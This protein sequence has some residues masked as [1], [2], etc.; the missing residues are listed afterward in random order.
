MHFEFIITCSPQKEKSYKM[1]VL[2]VANINGSRD[3]RGSEHSAD[4]YTSKHFMHM[5]GASITSRRGIS[6]DGFNQDNYFMYADNYSKIFIVADGHGI[7]HNHLRLIILTLKTISGPF[8]GMVSYFATMSLAKS[9]V[10]DSLYLTDTPAALRNAFHSCDKNLS[11]F[12][13]SKVYYQSA[14][15]LSKSHW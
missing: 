15:T 11:K 5:I 3:N 9:L 10:E 12:K 2:E 6:G 13:N 8:G 1:Q 14:L 4:I 7:F